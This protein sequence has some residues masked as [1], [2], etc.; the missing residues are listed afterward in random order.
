MELEQL[1]TLLT[2]A[3]VGLITVGLGG[4]VVLAGKNAHAAARRRARLN[5]PTPQRPGLTRPETPGPLDGL[6]NGVKPISREE[7]DALLEKD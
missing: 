6:I 2:V 4:G 3:S 5:D 1:Q 7:A